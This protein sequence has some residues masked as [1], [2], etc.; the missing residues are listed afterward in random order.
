MRYDRAA[1]PSESVV[2]NDGRSKSRAHVIFAIDASA[3]A[4]LGSLVS[5]VD[6]KLKG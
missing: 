1:S 4:S 5:F 3:F 6:G 2:Y